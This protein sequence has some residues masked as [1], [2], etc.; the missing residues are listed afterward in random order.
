MFHTFFVFSSSCFVFS[1]SSH[2]PVSPSLLFLLNIRNSF[3]CSFFFFSFFLSVFLIFLLFSLSAS[4]QPQFVIKCILCCSYQV[5]VCNVFILSPYRPRCPVQNHMSCHMIGRH[6][7]HFSEHQ[8]L[9][10]LK[11]SVS[12]ISHW[13]DIDRICSLNHFNVQIL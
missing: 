7:P 3:L 5:S 13:H 4:K 6:C 10:L 2:R 9:L 11:P 12:T 8:I 1:S